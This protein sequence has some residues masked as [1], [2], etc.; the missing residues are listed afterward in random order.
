M[1]MLMRDLNP[2]VIVIIEPPAI[3]YIHSR[4][5]WLAQLN[6]YFLIYAFNLLAQRSSAQ[7]PE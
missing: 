7:V 5:I 4:H 1:L 3:R 2:Y 6:C